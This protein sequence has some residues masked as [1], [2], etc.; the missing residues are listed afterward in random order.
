MWHTQR[1]NAVRSGH[2]NFSRDKA[3]DRRYNVSRMDSRLHSCTYIHSVKNDFIAQVK[4]TDDST[5]ESKFVNARSPYNFHRCHPIMFLLCRGFKYK[6]SINRR[7][8][9]LDLP[10]GRD[11]LG[12][13]RAPEF[14]VRSSL[15]SLQRSP[16]WKLSRDNNIITLKNATISSPRSYPIW[17]I[18]L[19]LCRRAPPRW[20]KQASCSSS[21]SLKFLDSPII[22]EN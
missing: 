8:N 7:R 18:L 6:P 13:W 14:K 4:Y 22:E 3:I 5:S 1:F 15:N 19:E 9:I 16:F 11:L 12:R 10:S 20:G 21:N 17:I 2:S